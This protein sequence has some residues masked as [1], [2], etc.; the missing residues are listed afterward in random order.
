MKFKLGQLIAGSI[1][2]SASSAFYSLPAPAQRARNANVDINIVTSKSIDNQ[3]QTITFNR[4][5]QDNY[6]RFKNIKAE[7]IKFDKTVKIGDSIYLSAQDCPVIQQTLA[8]SP[9]TR[10]NNLKSIAEIKTANGI[11]NGPL[12]PKKG[13]CVHKGREA[14]ERCLDKYCINTE[15]WGRG[16][17]T[18]PKYK[19]CVNRA[20]R[21]IRGGCKGEIPEP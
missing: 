8:S 18:D 12:P 6:N 16:P 14:I 13:N 10:I 2:L 1:L 5:L 4:E 20:Q 11:I 3:V 17:C 9:I 7:S 15:Q 21:Y 19:G